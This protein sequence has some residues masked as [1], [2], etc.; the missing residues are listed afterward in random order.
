MSD[1]SETPERDNSGRFVSRKSDETGP[2]HV[3]D[4]SE[5]HPLAGALFGWTVGKGVGGAFFWG[6][7][8]LSVL[9]IL[10]DLVVHHH[11]YF[12]VEGSFGFYGFFGFIAFAF[13][14]LMGWPLGRLLRRDENF[15][16]DADAPSQDEEDK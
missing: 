6:V 1:Q 12:D 4:R 3:D 9:L 10:G 8:A 15:Y 13:V 5:W 2:A 11:P 14:V 7:L 16:G